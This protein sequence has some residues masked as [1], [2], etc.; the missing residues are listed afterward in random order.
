MKNIQWKELADLPIDEVG[1]KKILILTEGR[2]NS[3]NLYVCTAYWNVFESDGL[4]DNYVKYIENN[5][6]R[7]NV[8]TFI[9]GEYDVPTEKIH[10]WMMCSDLV[11]LYQKENGKDE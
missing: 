6:G 2:H 1:T 10:A 4:A 5:N 7:L 11:E 9:T 8:G 3:E